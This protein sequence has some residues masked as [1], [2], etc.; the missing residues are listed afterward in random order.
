MDYA[1]RSLELHRQ[2]RGKIEIVARAKVDSRE[3]LSSGTRKGDH[4]PRSPH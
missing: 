1:K 2:L 4:S 3:A